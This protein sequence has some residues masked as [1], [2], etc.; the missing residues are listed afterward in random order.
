[1]TRVFVTNL[2]LIPSDV[3]VRCAQGLCLWRNSSSDINDELYKGYP[4]G[5]T[6]GQTNE[7]VAGTY[8]HYISIY[9]ICGRQYLFNIVLAA[10]DFLNS[11]KNTFNVSIW[12]NA[13]YKEDG[14]LSPIKMARF[15]RS[16]NMVY[17]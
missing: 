2:I 14:G 13:T 9:I 6:E 5:N 17:V 16:V 4:R 10:F 3:E 1:M 11:N 8:Y 12:Y 15:P 7:I